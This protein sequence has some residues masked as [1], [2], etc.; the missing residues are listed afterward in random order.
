MTPVEK[1]NLPEEAE[2][3]I[4]GE[5]Y[6]NI[7]RKPLEKLGI[8]PLFMP[9]NSNV[10]PRLSG[11]ADLSVLHMG[12]ERLCLAT[13]LRESPFAEQ[14]SAMGFL[15]DSPEMQQSA[16]YP[17]DAQ[18]N[19]CIC[20]KHAFFNPSVVPNSIVHFLTSN[21]LNKIACR[22][23]YTKCSVCVV[24]E[25]AIITADRGIE[26]LARAAGMDVLLIEPGFVAL[27][28]FPY[29][30]IGGAAFKI[31]RS[32]LAF[33]GTLKPCKNESEILSFLKHHQ[34]EPVYLTNRPLFDIGSAVP[35]SEK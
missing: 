13:Y 20:G 23:G 24:D 9:D 29:G 33:T 32:K 34:V 27:D 22:Q 7:L 2:S 25:G 26:G 16:V 31:T 8:N 35:I 14:L 1:P 15:V 11:H 4:I 30:F 10:D 12:R 18:L 21:E 5:K 3:I 19:L 6:S 28:G 17:G